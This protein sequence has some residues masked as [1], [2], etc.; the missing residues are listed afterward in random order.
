MFRADWL[1]IVIVYIR[2]LLIK[3]WSVHNFD[4]ATLSGFAMS[5]FATKEDLNERK[6]TILK[7]LVC[8]KIK[9]WPK[10]RNAKCV[11]KLVVFPPLFVV[12]VS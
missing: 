9:N 11:L 4:R 8:L 12:F 6:Q 5:E 7:T 3:D 10:T 1:E 2:Y